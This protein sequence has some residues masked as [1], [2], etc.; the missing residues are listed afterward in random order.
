M[1]NL[2]AEVLGMDRLKAVEGIAEE[3]T[4]LWM[5]Q[6]KLRLWREACLRRVDQQKMR[7]WRAA[8]LRRVD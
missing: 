6:L 7:L 8:H 5:Y 2:A 4:E 3:I 1:G